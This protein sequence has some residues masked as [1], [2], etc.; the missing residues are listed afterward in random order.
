MFN[1]MY[2]VPRVINGSRT[3]SVAINLSSVDPISDFLNAYNQIFQMVSSILHVQIPEFGLAPRIIA[4]GP[5][6]KM[7][8]LWSGLKLT[9]EHTMKSVFSSFH[10]IIVQTKVMA[11]EVVQLPLTVCII[12]V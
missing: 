1:Y 10:K 12:I 4:H 11:L 3:L 5:M 6:A 7:T 8:K 2:T 9:L